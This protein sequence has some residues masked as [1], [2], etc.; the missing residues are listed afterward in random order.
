[1]ENV[2]IRM[3][4]KTMVFSSLKF[5]DLNQIRIDDRANIFF[6]GQRRKSS[7]RFINGWN[8]NSRG[9]MKNKMS[10]LLFC[11]LF[12]GFSSLPLPSMVAMFFSFRFVRQRFNSR[13]DFHFRLNSVR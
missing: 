2:L 12:T 7:S 11:F 10:G 3:I 8:A 13:G 5:V 1:M 9:K 4:R 6:S